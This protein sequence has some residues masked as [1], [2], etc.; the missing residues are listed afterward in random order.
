MR[1]RSTAASVGSIL[2]CGITPPRLGIS[3]LVHGLLA[4]AA[5]SL[6]VLA[7]AMAPAIASAAD[8]QPATPSSFCSAVGS[9]A[10]QCEELRSVAVDQSNGNVYVLD[11]NNTAGAG[12]SR[13]DEF[14]PSGGFLRAFGY[15][16]I[17]GGA[18]GTGTT[19]SSTS[20]S[21]VLTT[22]KAFIPGQAILGAGIPA[23]T[24][25]VAVGAGTITLSQAATASASGVG[26]SVAEGSSNIAQNE[27]QTITIGGA[28][29]GG[30]F[31]LTY[32]TPNPSNSTATATAIPFNA[33]ALEVEGK[34]AALTNIGSGNIS[35]TGANGG[36][37]TVEFKG[38]RFADTNVNQ[39]TASP[40][41]LTPPGAKTVTIATVQEGTSLETCTAVTTCKAGTQAGAGAFGNAARGIAVDPGTHIVYAVS[42]GA[43]VAYFDG[44]TGAFLGEFTGTV[45]NSPAP[46]GALPATFATT[47][48]IAVDVH[49]SAQHYVYVATG[50]GASSVIDKFTVPVGATPPG[51]VCQITGKETASVT[52]CHG[53]ASKD[54]TFNG[55]SFSAQKGGNLTVDNSGNIFV[56]EEVGRNAVSEFDSTGAFV[57]KLAATV[58]TAVATDTAGHLFVADGG[59]SEGGLHVEGLDVSTGAVVSDFGAGTIG[60]SLGLAVDASGLPASNGHIYVG[61]RLNK[62]VWHYGAG[63]ATAPQLKEQESAA[64]SPISVEF[65]AKV[66]VRAGGQDFGLTDCHFEYVTQAAF[67]ATGFTDLSSGGS[68]PCASPA[69]GQIRND[70]QYHLVQ[71]SVETLTAS[72][73]YRWRTVAANAQGTTN[74]AAEPLVTGAAAPPTIEEQLL[75]PITTGGAEVKAKINPNFGQVNA[76]NSHFGSAKDCEFRYTTDPSFIFGVQG[77]PCQNPSNLENRGVG[78]L[79]SSTLTGLAPD[80]TYYWR[81]YAANAEGSVQGTVQTFTTHKEPATV[82]TDPVGALGETFAALK[83]HVDNHGDPLPG[84]SCEFQ[85]ALPADSA[86]AAPVKTLSCGT[87]S[88]SGPQAVEAAATGL[89]PNTSYIYRVRAKNMGNEEAGTGF[90]NGASQSFVTTA[91][92]DVTQSAVGS[93]ET[94]ATLIASINPNGLA[95]TYHIE[96]V[97]EATFQEDQPNGFQRATKTPESSSIGADHTNHKVTTEI[98]EL[99]PETTYR[100]QFVAHN[101]DGTTEA[102]PARIFVTKGPLQHPCANESLREENASMSLPECR[103]YE[104]VTPVDKNLGSADESA[105]PRASVAWDGEAVGLCTSAQFGDPPPENGSVC[106]TF[107]VS[108]RGAEGWR[109]KGMIPLYCPRIQ[110]EAAH[111]ASLNAT[112]FGSANLDFAAISRPESPSCT[113]YPALAAHAPQPGKYLYRADL[114]ATPAAY[115]LLTPASAFTPAYEEFTGEYAGASDDFSHIVYTSS[116]QQTPDSPATNV[117][118]LYDWHNGALSLVSVDPTGAPFG[119][120]SDLPYTGT[121]I[122]ASDGVNAVSEGGNRIFFQNGSG[123]GE[124]IYLRENGTATYWVSQQECNPACSNASAAD[125][126]EW[127]TLSGSRVFFASTAKLT[128]DDTSITGRDLYMFTKGP[129][130]AGEQNLTLLSHDNEPEDGNAAKILGVIGISDDGN[131]VYFAADGQIVAGKPTASGAKVYRWR[132][133]GGSPSIDY[134]ATLGIPPISGKPKDAQNWSASENGA[135][136]F[137]KPVS[138]LVSPSGA[139]L[140]VQT[141][142]ALDPIADG[143]SDRD[144]YRWTSSEGWTCLSCQLPGVPSLAGESSIDSHEAVRADAQRALLRVNYELRTPMS[145]DGSHVFFATPDAL[146]PEDTNDLE[147]VYEWHNGTVS[148]IS[149][150]T[151]AQSAA[152]IGASRSGNDVFFITAG[153]LLGRDIDVAT[154]IYDARVG[155]GFATSPPKATCEG[156]G[157]KG[158]GTRAAPTDPIGSANNE[159]PG[160]LPEKRCRKGFVRRHGKCVPKNAEKH[161]RRASKRAGSNRRTAK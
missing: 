31:T 142:I 51:Y 99:Q 27:L 149:T 69:A 52:E 29:T 141:E 136:Q 159:G 66:N 44:D 56:A 147:D 92:P 88:G 98:K 16:V 104:M 103:A 97:T 43:K 26:L 153:P 62:K 115:D 134:L 70:G 4:R 114:R 102:T 33:S 19:N 10:G 110:D 41:G 6:A 95:T 130:P 100:Y 118:R 82:T 108:Q 20:I 83:G 13:I 24:T 48:G 1:I 120:P 126:F 2:P 54:G 93:T 39:I 35:V 71:A 152:L 155:G 105:G 78:K 67:N 46:G 79:T 58:P 50:S 22:S 55:I 86:F 60:A 47:S 113:A 80:T 49:N 76:A 161:R 38:T 85:V 94:T 57:R 75:G 89:S 137:G 21:A 64:S 117:S 156:E 73:A 127:A 63:T 138:R 157:C 122:G 109:T 17:P 36:P 146:V 145:D 68:A 28:P 125:R 131:T 144:V 30:T 59:T 12:N 7:I 87:V 40:S 119:T 123:P 121:I 101:D 72:T 34:L 139:A 111:Q 77:K 23:G 143:D 81:T 42:G 90:A 53:T 106:N 96:Y 150:G 133:N 32:T 18:T 160:N 116:G 8:Y 148:L 129:N 112:A 15:D 158:A 140:L 25:I 61:D 84:A 65:K 132:W 135:Q 154:D 124:E 107:Y 74:G 128:D 91:R 9:G 45:G 5:I 37:W 151:G 14:D 11:M 3:V